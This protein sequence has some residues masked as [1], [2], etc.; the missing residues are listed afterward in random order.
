MIGLEELEGKYMK[1]AD[2]LV[3]TVDS[4]DNKSGRK[5]QEK[6]IKCSNCNHFVLKH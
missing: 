5:N 1:E 3:Q 4:R 6:P 2:F